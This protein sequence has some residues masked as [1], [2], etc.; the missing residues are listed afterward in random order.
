MVLHVPCESVMIQC[1]AQASVNK[2]LQHGKQPGKL[3]APTQPQNY[4]FFWI[5]ET[6]WDSSHDWRAAANEHRLFRKD[7][8]ERVRN[9]DAL[10]Q[11]APRDLRWSR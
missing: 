8:L 3:P 9:G 1:S 11:G 10:C 6:G 7:R 5:I 2:H 4:D